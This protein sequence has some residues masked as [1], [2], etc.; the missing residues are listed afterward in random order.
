MADLRGITGGVRS[1]I[2]P[3]IV[4]AGFGKID[5]LITLDTRDLGIDAADT[6][7]DMGRR[8]EI[9]FAG[10][11]PYRRDDEFVLTG[12]AEKSKS[13]NECSIFEN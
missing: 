10:E 13:G 8:G 4:G 1:G 2:G 3:D 11:G 6:L 5:V 12:N 9:S 7:F